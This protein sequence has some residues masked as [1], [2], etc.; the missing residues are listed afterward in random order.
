MLKTY[1]VL[2]NGTTVA[3]IADVKYLYLILTETAVLCS[4]FLSLLFKLAASPRRRG[5]T[6]ASRLTSQQSLCDCDSTYLTKLANSRFATI[7][8]H[9]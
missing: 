3:E 9:I 4:V 7:A 5:L 2:G 8:L 1:K 6:V